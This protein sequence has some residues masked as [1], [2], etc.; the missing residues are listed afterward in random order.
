[1]SSV[2]LFVILLSKHKNKTKQKNPLY[3]CSPVQF[4]KYFH[5]DL[6][7]QSIQQCLRTGPENY[8]E[9]ENNE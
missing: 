8:N 5:R 4:A 2:Y 7:H 9:R 6:I 3:L 1:M